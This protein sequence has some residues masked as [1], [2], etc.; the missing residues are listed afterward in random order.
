VLAPRRLTLPN[1]LRGRN[2]RHAAGMLLTDI[3]SDMMFA[4]SH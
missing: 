1:E 2:R 4:S 3:M